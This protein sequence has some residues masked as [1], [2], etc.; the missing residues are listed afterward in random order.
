MASPRVVANLG[1]GREDI[2]TDDTELGAEDEADSVRE[3][4]GSWSSTEVD[5]GVEVDVNAEVDTAVLVSPS[6]VGDTAVELSWAG[7]R[8]RE[9]GKGV[10]TEPAGANRGTS[11][12]IQY[13]VL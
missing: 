11:I 13:S 6:G 7:T 10:G 3:D 5:A 2:V 9:S 4:N 12:G 1:I 8:G